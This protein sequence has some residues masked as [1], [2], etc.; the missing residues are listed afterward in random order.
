MYLR[1]HF[2]VDEDVLAIDNNR[3]LLRNTDD[4]DQR[5]ILCVRCYKMT[6]DD[7]Y[8]QVTCSG[9]VR[10]CFEMSQNVHH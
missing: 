7:D 9:N 1:G 6:N 5:S 3:E 2:L 4:V 10:E 8:Y